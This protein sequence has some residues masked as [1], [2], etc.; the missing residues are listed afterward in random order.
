MRREIEIGIIFVS[1]RTQVSQIQ[2]LQW[3]RAQLLHAAAH[4]HHRQPAPQ[5]NG[6]LRGKVRLTAK[7]IGLYAKIENLILTVS[8]PK[9]EISNMPDQDDDYSE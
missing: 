1:L 3:Q 5:Q 4:L 9:L 2:C 8:K 7:T 6:L